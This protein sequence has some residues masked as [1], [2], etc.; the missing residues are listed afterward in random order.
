MNPGRKKLIQA[1]KV[2]PEIEMP[3]K[4]FKALYRDIIGNIPIHPDNIGII[5]HRLYNEP[6]MVK[7]MSE[8]R[9]RLSLVK[10]KH[11]PTD[12]MIKGDLIKN[13]SVI[14]NL[15]NFMSSHER[16]D[17]AYTEM[18]QLISLAEKHPRTV[19]TKYEIEKQSLQMEQQRKQAKIEM[20]KIKL[21][22]PVRTGMIIPGT[23]KIKDVKEIYEEH[24]F[25]PELSTLTEPKQNKLARALR[26]FKKQYW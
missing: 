13:F 22:E 20:S 12:W 14:D 5:N 3:G 16:F 11:V 2:K 19:Y 7:L 24:E 25:V 15:G 23:P 9:V 21:H 1:L 26:W 8:T 4:E 18:K 10:A 6:I 17:D